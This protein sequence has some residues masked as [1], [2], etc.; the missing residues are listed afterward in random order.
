M[1]MAALTD[2]YERQSARDQR[3]LQIGAVAVA[4]IL[5]AGLYLVPQRALEKARATLDG[6]REL[7]TYMRQVGPSLQASGAG[8]E[9]QPITESFIVFI[10]RT[11]REHGL[12]DAITGSPP[13]GNGTYRVTLEGA[14]FNLLV[15]WVYQMSSRHGVKVE[16]ANVTGS[17]GPGRVN[18]SVQLRPPA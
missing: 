16:A 10:D 9:V 1:S 2:W 18:A 7:L 8:V 11:A 12:G 13:A 5:L 3:V 14:D 4:L 6:R 17:G 15:N